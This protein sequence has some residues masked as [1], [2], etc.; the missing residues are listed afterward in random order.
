MIDFFLGI[1]IAIFAV[2]GAFFWY[3]TGF[4]IVAIIWML[5]SDIAFGGFS[6]LTAALMAAIWFANPSLAMMVK[7]DPSWAIAMIAGYFILG[8]AW[9]ACKWVFSINA[10]VRKY[11]R[12][13]QEY[14]ENQKPGDAF[15]VNEFVKWL[16]NKNGN[17]DVMQ[18]FNLDYSFE[19]T[20]DV[21]KFSAPKARQH[22]GAIMKWISA[23]PLSMIWT[24]I[25]DP[26]KRIV[27]EIYQ[28]I[29]GVFQKISNYLTKSIQADFNK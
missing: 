26:F 13:K 4:M 29:T 9:A 1:Y 21:Y 5:D 8:T 23:W 22:K 2:G 6:F 11:T 15:D 7:A 18:M 19:S 28:R 17:N 20:R 24:L 14:C 10:L 12:M 25:N 16:S 27:E 3:G